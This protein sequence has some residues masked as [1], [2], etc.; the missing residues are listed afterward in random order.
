MPKKQNLLLL[1]FK[2]AIYIYLP[3]ILLLYIIYSFIPGRDLVLGWERILI[4]SAIIGLWTINNY[5]SKAIETDFDNINDIKQ[6]ITNKRWKI[7]EQ[8]E[9]SLLIKPTFD[10]PFRLFIDSSVMIKYSKEG[11]LIEGPW[12]YVN[13]LTKDIK[14]IGNIWTKKSTELIG[15]FL[16]I[17]LVSL[18]VLRDLGLFWEVNKIRHNNHIKNVEVIDIAPDRVIG[19]SVVNTNN[20]GFAVENDD[21]IFYIDDELSLVRVDK[22]F[23]NKKLLIEMPSRSI[24]RLNIAGDWIYYSSGE[25]LNRISFDG[26]S[27]ETIYKLGYLL[28]IYMKDNWIYFINFSDNSNVYKMDLNGGNLER[29]LMVNSSDIAIY[30]DRMIFSH[31]KDEKPYVESIGLDGSD[32]RLEFEDIAE[33]LVIYGDYYYYIGENYRL[34]RRTMDK[35]TKPQILVDSEVSSYT[36]AGNEIFYSLHSSDVGYPGKGLYKI[37]LDGRENVQITN[38]EKVQGFA[39]VGNWLLF[40]SLDGQHLPRLNRMDLVTPN[41]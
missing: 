37:G 6:S 15:L 16:I 8:K 26:S 41:P 7:I 2:G 21:Y 35:S 10:F 18:P 14:G 25:T 11:I 30:G 20:Y 31:L 32:R 29:F 33:S 13:N 9:D 17:L 5:K 19:N 28:N 22:D 36:I 12:Y 1:A 27:N 23:Q 24:M 3:V 38:M 40:H 39:K 4:Y 34:Y